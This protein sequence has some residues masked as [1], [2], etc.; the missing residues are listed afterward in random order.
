MY[1]EYCSAG[2]SPAEYKDGYCGNCS[3][4]V[5]YLAGFLSGIAV[6]NPSV[7]KIME[8]HRN[9]RF[10]NVTQTPYYEEETYDWVQ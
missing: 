3:A 8:L 4:L 1:C 5:P 7:A 2:I 6:V 9:R 10:V